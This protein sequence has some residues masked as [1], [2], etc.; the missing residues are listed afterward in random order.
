MEH[1]QLSLFSW[2]KA[3]L[4]EGYEQ[5]VVFSFDEAEFIFRQLGEKYESADP[6]MEDALDCTRYWKNVFEQFESTSPAKSIAILHDEI[7]QFDF[8]KTWG[9]Q[10]FRL[11][12]IRHLTELMQQQNLFYLNSHTT[13]SDLFL[14]LREPEKAGQLLTEQVSSSPLDNKLRFRLAQIH[15]QN[16]QKG[17]AKRHYTL[18]LLLNP[19]EV[20]RP[21][22][23]CNEIAGLIEEYGP[24]MTPAYGWV[25]GV[26]PLVQ[27]PD[28][29]T[30][31]G[32]SH[33]N[34]LTCYRLLHDAEKASKKSDM[35]ACV[36]YRKVL[37]Q[38]D[39]E[40]YQEYFALL[41]RRKIP[42]FQ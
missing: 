13:L 41:S 2:Q 33:V 27:V 10:Q 28:D 38:T 18:G 31:A 22:L 19:A 4:A 20:P 8:Q 32:D 25:S 29:I 1:S 9:Q 30:P 5:L 6:E 34:A 15:W 3:V 16:M 40:F 21:F 17:E 14:Q 42:R 37:K 23:E 36:E 26:L 39:P 35:D 12:L 24:E 7:S 11:A